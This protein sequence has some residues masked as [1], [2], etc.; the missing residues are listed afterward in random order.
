MT[1]TDLL[2]ERTRAK[3]DARFPG[4]WWFYVTKEFEI[5]IV[6]REMKEDDTS[7]NA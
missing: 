1:L 5:W 2:D 7:H 3:L 6:G 4:G